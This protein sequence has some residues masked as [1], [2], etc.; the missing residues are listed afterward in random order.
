MKF[1]RLTEVGVIPVWMPLL[2]STRAR[3]PHDIDPW[4]LDLDLKSYHKLHLL[5]M[6]FQPKLY[7]Y[8][9]SFISWF[10]GP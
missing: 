7:W 5:W 10:I 2:K 1:D 9:L 4:P 6:R 8:F 3:S